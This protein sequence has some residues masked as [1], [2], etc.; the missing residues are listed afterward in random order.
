MFVHKFFRLN[1]NPFCFVIIIA[2]DIYLPQSLLSNLSVCLSVCLYLFVDIYRLDG[3]WW[4][5]VDFLFRM[6]AANLY[7]KSKMIQT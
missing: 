5:V 7:D 4:M 1:F 3:R 6:N 2:S